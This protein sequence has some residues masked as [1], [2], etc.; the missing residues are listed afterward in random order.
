M[1]RS[2][3]VKDIA[4]PEFES[5]LPKR[6]KI[7]KFQKQ[8]NEKVKPQ[9]LK[10]IS[11]DEQ[12]D[13][14]TKETTEGNLTGSDQPTKQPSFRKK[15]VP[16]SQ[17]DQFVSDNVQIEVIKHDDFEV[18]EEILSESEITEIVM[19]DPGDANN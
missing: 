12:S 16:K 2:V 1:P 4:K 19:R 6:I 17:Q 14:K 9:K 7:I 15:S 18:L 5:G 3:S 13:V 11:L 8:I 10:H